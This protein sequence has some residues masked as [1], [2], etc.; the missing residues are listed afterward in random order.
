MGSVLGVVR[1]RRRFLSGCGGFLE[2]AFVSWVWRGSGGS[3]V[4]V[5]EAGRFRLLFFYLVFIW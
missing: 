4:R 5:G 3:K 1:R 2:E